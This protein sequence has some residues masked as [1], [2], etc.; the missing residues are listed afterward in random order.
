M[1]LTQWETK[2]IT[3]AQATN[4]VSCALITKQEYQLTDALCQDE[5][6]SYAEEETYLNE[7]ICAD[8]FRQFI[9]PL[10]NL[11]FYRIAVSDEGLKVEYGTEVI[12]CSLDIN[13]REGTVTK[14]I[15]VHDQPFYLDENG[16]A[17]VGDPESVEYYA[18][19]NI[20]NQIFSYMGQ[21]DGLAA[22]FN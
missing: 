12:S 5:R 3:V 1:A 15:R 6:I 8:Y 11:A 7:E 18:I 19:K 22:L 21:K 4:M 9:L 16:Y 20:D 10:R 13:Q 17:V 14:W 2:D